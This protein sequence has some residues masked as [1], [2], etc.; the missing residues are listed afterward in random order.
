MN[1]SAFFC[2]G[3]ACAL[4][5]GC[6][7]SSNPAG[8]TFASSAN[9][10]SSA[11]T[12]VPSPVATISGTV[13]NITTPPALVGT[14]SIDAAPLTVFVAGTSLS[15]V[16]NTNGQFTLEGV[17]VGFA[18][19]SFQGPGVDALLRVG[20]LQPGQQVDLVVTVNGSSATFAELR[21]E[22]G[23]DVEVN[24]TIARLNGSC[25]LVTFV[26]RSITIRTNTV[27]NIDDGCSHLRNGVTIEVKGNRQRDGSILAARI[28]REDADDDDDNGDSGRRR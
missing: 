24:G 7:D 10:T 26:L 9:A 14:R 27:T 2:F 4:A 6:S 13:Q 19:L 28:E 3:L 22:R 20:T 21:N 15:T 23:N 8:P 16:V 12:S 18:N 11:I 17:P 25:P 1:M 5:T